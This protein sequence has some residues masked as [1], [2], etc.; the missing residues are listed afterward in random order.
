MASTILEPR[1]AKLDRADYDSLYI[2]EQN[3]PDYK[4]P[5]PYFVTETYMARQSDELCCMAGNEVEVLFKS[6][7][8]WWTIRYVF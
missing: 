2:P 6:Y 8:G 1:R 4:R 5:V 3:T 7:S